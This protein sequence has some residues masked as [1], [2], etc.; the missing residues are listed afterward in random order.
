[1]DVRMS[2][3][4][5][6]A[7]AAQGDRGPSL[8]LVAEE[9]MLKAL[10]RAGLEQASE[11]APHVAAADSFDFIRASG[12]SCRTAAVLLLTGDALMLRVLA[13][14]LYEIHEAFAALPLALMR[15]RNISPSRVNL[16]GGAISLGH[17]LGMSGVRMLLSLT[18]ALRARELL[19]GCAV[20]C[21][22]ADAATAIVLEAL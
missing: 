5:G 10:A 22:G 7:D 15:R 1:M 4:L 14:D 19:Y 17:P 21:N 20:I 8:A 3:I 2:R 18:T 11:T 9:A 12:F 13:V 16:H 6:F